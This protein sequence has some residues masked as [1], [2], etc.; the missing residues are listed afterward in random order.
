MSNRLGNDD[1]V[2]PPKT[3]Q[4]KL[5]PAEIKDK[6][7]GYKLLENIDDLK[8]M[9]GTEI[10]YFVYENIGNKKNLKVE[11]K[12]RLGGRLIKVDSNFQ[13]VVLASGTPPNQKTWSVQ[14]K[15]SEIYYKLKIEDIV[16]H[17]ED[18]IKQVKNKYE[19]EI[20]NL[21]NEISK[22]K[23]EKKSIIIKYNDLVDKYAKLKGK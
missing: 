7:L 14:L 8:E 6:L 19:I 16:L 2:R 5:T 22:L 10:R 4:D 9:I 11:K 17:Q 23:D 15:D 1:Y 13:Y 3:L 20:D 21:K 18:Q 12:F